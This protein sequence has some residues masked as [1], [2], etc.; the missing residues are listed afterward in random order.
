MGNHPSSGLEHPA[1][2]DSGVQSS[3]QQQGGRTREGIRQL[4]RNNGALGLSKIELDARCQPSGLYVSCA[5]DY[6]HIRRLIGDGKLAA[7]CKG[8]E[9]VQNEG[10]RECPICFFNY[11]AINETKCC[12]A[13]ICTECY[14]QV[15]DPKEPSTACPFCNQKLSVNVAKPLSTEDIEERKKEE[16][17]LI[18]A[19]IRASS[20]NNNVDRNDDNTNQKEPPPSLKLLSQPP[21]NPEFGA[22]LEQNER[23]AMMRKR[24]TSGSSGD[25]FG[26]ETSAPLVAMTPEERR[27][28][29]AEM[30]AQ[31]QHPLARRMDQ[32]EEER[33]FQN[34]QQYMQSSQYRSRM[35]QQ[36]R[37]RQM[38]ARRLLMHANAGSGRRPRDWN[39]IV[40]AFENSSAGNAVHSLDDLVV[41]EAAIMLSNMEQEQLQQNQGRNRDQPSDNDTENDFAARQAQE[42]FPLARARVGGGEGNALL[43]HRERSRLRR[44]NFENNNPHAPWMMAA[45]MTEEEQMAMAIAASLRESG[46]NGAN[47]NSENDADDTADADAVQQ[48]EE[49][50]N[51]L[52][53][54]APD[55]E[56]RHDEND[57]DN[58]NNAAANQIGQNV[59]TT[60][61]EAND[62]EDAALVSVAA[63]EDEETTVARAEERS[64][65]QQGI[66]TMSVSTTNKDDAVVTNNGVTFTTVDSK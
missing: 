19:K 11:S 29:E 35:A 34:Q 52:D 16:Q 23:V 38:Q 4:L 59:A 39:R 17:Q 44:Q 56:N 65:E 41:L 32:E 62:Q 22:S 9:E 1:Q 46:A 30:K 63:G 3:S 2:G 43:A 40:Q 15:R 50:S 33:R 28:L 48:N 31:H 58:N 53:A 55:S 60:D 27:A 49:E 24:S 18:E 12:Q 21:N 13:N 25:N 36:E 26:S 5:W 45:L 47:V 57:N 64:A 51:A 37:L 7:R 54:A 42:G 66:A 10:D 14:L 20:N 61:N 8:T 6:K